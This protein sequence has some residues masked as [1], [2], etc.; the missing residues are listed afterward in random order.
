VTAVR[1]LTVHQV[2]RRIEM[3]ALPF[4]LTFVMIL[5]VSGILPAQ[6]KVKLE[7]KLSVGDRI[8]SET[9][10]ENYVWANFGQLGGPL[11][12]RA[13]SIETT[14]TTDVVSVDKNGVI[15]A[16]VISEESGAIEQFVDGKTNT[17]FI[18]ATEHPPRIFKVSKTGQVV[19]C[20]IGE[21]KPRHP[22]DPF[23]DVDNWIAY[24]TVQQFS[25]LARLPD[26][27][28]GVGDIWTT[29]TPV[30]GPDGRELKLTTNF[31]LFGFG[32][33]GE[34]DCAWIQSEA[35]LPF[36]IGFSGDFEGYSSVAAEGRF[37]WS[38]RSCF[39]YEEGRMI[40]DRSLMHFVMMIEIPLQERTAKTSITTL[41]NSKSTTSLSRQAQ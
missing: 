37:S 41:G 14:T 8:V 13:G 40:K 36:K 22:R 9:S 18:P 17:T 39:A 33:V 34:Y 12:E 29:E 7:H 19:W 15:E 24:I 31:K 28:V 27:K 11:F 35:K 30:K 5:S 26:K 2:L 20:G 1:S 4:I 23:R 21:Y 3:K 38:V 32:K 16:K 10:M 25:P 6:E